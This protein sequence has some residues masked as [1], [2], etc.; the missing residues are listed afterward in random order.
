MEIV[1]KPTDS[2]VMYDKNP[3]INDRAIVPVANS[4][5]E[6][7][8]KV[9]ILL[10]K[11]NVIIAGHTRLKA[12]KS[13]GMKEVPCIMCEDLTPEQV[14]AFRIIDNKTAEISN[15]NL[16]KL[17]EELGDIHIDMEEFG[18][19]DIPVVDEL[20]EYLKDHEEK[21]PKEK[22][23]LRIQCPYCGEWFDVDE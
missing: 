18:F 13:L 21:P 8:F 23:P 3:R 14:K 12:A 10:D 4:I 9:P 5:K 19:Y 6:F 20:G 1:Y 17:N 11:D 2:L 15:W 22:E 16:E 7:G